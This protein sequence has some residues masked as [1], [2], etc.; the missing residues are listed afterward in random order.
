MTYE[1]KPARLVVCE[2]TGAWAVGLRRELAG[3]GLRVWETRSM[4]DCG[5]LLAESPASFVILELGG[6][7]I[8]ELL[9][10][11]SSWQ[12]Q[13]PMFRF[14]VAADR[15]LASYRWLM[16]EAGAVDFICSMRQIGSLAQT[17]CRHLARVPPVP[18]SFTERIWVNLPWG[19]GA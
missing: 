1:A 15:E 5:M 6:E 9:T 19:K 12:M 18:Q 3:A 2:R 16:Q 10:L 11:I 17:A 8:R 13:F 14:A 4:D 7:K